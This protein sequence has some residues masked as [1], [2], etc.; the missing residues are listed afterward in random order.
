MYWFDY[1]DNFF[2]V[3]KVYKENY[4]DTENEVGGSIVKVVFC[5][6]DFNITDKKASSLQHRMIYTELFVSAEILYFLS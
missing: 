5:G 4:I 3:I 1:F 6:W 2:R